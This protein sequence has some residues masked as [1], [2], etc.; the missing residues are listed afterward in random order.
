MILKYFDTAHLSHVV[1]ELFYL[2]FDENDIP[3][4][5]TVLPIS[6]IS[7]THI[8]GKNQSAVFKKQKTVLN[9]LIITG[10]FYESYQFLVNS[11]GHSYGI[12][13]HP[14][15]IYK[16]TKTD[17]SKLTEKHL[18]LSDVSKILHD[19]IKPIFIRY[20]DDIPKLTKTLKKI[21]L[22]LPLVKNN[23]IDQIDKAIDFIR[24]KEGMLNTYE[25]L[26]H[27]SFSQ[28]TLETQFKKIVGLT[29]GKYIRLNRFLKLMRKY[30]GKEIGL[31]DLIY[32]YNY[33][34]HSHFAKDFKY[35]MKQSPK[36]YFNS[37][38]PFLNE[39]LNK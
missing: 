8:Y 22:S 39:Y 20:Q 24:V 17:V 16:L 32:M 7:I 1:E 2:S 21:F 10:Q 14:T 18:P 15:A 38:H 33:Y 12:S 25:L 4:E 19:L 6:C 11:K 36:E 9:G 29:P 28:K 31:K 26:D 27:V 23:T 34:D 3:F 35:F 5:S 13:F 30:E 37:E